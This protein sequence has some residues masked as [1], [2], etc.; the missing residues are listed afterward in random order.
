MN[1]ND[2]VVVNNTKKCTDVDDVVWSVQNLS[3]V[4]YV[5]AAITTFSMRL[6]LKATRVST[7][8]PLIVI[9]SNAS[10]CSVP[11]SG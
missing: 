10:A 4:A 8:E 9:P 5:H 1:G 11:A 2:T 7:C 3:R 6:S